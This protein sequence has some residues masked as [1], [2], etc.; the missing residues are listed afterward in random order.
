MIGA[1]PLDEAVET[2]KKY[3]KARKGV[4]LSENIY[5]LGHQYEMT[6]HMYRIAKKWLDYNK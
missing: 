4:E 3:V 2:I 6:G 5:Y 1:I